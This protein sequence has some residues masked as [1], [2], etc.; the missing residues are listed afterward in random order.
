MVQVGK[1]VSEESGVA[2]QRTLSVPICALRQRRRLW[3]AS[4]CP[5]THPERL[6]RPAGTG[7]C[8]YCRVYTTLV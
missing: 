3:R 6:C 2:E 8:V 1:R 4:F 5:P 7:L